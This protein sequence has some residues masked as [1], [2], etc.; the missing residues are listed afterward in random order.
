LASEVSKASAS[1]CSLREA[2]DTL[3]ARGCR[4]DF[5]SIR[6]IVK[7]FAARARSFQEAGSFVEEGLIVAGCRVVISIDGG[8]LRIRK[9]KAGRKT[10]K[11]R[12]RYSTA[13][14]EP[15]LFIIYIANEDGRIEKKFCPFIDASLEGP[16]AIFALL[17]FYL[18]KIKIH[19]ASI[20]VFA[21]DGAL[22]IWERA[23]A[24][25]AELGLSTEK[26]RFVLDFYH[27]VEHLAKLL[28]LKK[29]PKADL[30]LYLTKYRRIL[31]K[32]KTSEFFDFIE[33]I[34][35]GSRSS[36]IIR[37]RNYFLKNREKMRYQ[38]IA[39][40]GLPIG[41]GAVESAIRRVINMRLKGP[42]I[43]WHEDTANQML[44]LRCYYKAGR[45]G[46]LQK[47]ASLPAHVAIA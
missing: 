5:K 26:I 43:F 16:E 11:G 24:L 34:T 13:W 38:L 46:M 44:M 25:L 35:K 42:G 1:L 12:R 9:D 28:E 37:E 33:S 8:R 47:M 15:K 14:R 31:L 18:L 23:Y 41:S 3:A 36:A 2:Q 22:W 20:V 17:R 32:G 10:K 7:R 21:A 40:L 30:K 45:W 4:L 27:A 29:F 19:L 39:S 6:N